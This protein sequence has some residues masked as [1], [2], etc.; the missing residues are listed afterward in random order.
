MRSLFASTL[1]VLSACSS[2]NDADAGENPADAS[3]GPDA[4]PDFY[5]PE[6]FSLT[7]FLSQ[8]PDR[9]FTAAGDATEPDTDYA[10][11]LET[12]V[13]IIVID[14][15]EQETPITANSFVW[16]ARHHYYDTIAFHRVIEGFVAQAG[17]PRTALEDPSTRDD[18]GYMFDDEIVGSLTY[19]GP[20]VVGMANA[21]EDTNGSQFFITFSAQPGLNGD[22]TV[23]GRVIEGEDLFPLIVRGEPPLDPT[24]MTQVY[25]VQK[26]L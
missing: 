8:E 10:A 25:I 18:P 6:G 1:L 7:P 2:S 4:D 5:L 14:L 21:G 17:D 19:D 12:D 22:Y 11:V 16:L 26:P 20:G 13:G 9:S 3:V 15:F 24:R 23:F